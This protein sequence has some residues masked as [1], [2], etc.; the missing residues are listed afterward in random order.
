MEIFCFPRFKERKLEYKFETR[1][2]TYFPASSRVRGNLNLRNLKKKGS[3]SSFD[4]EKRTVRQS[5]DHQSVWN[6]VLSRL[7]ACARLALDNYR[8][9]IKIFVERA[10]VSCKWALAWM[11]EAAA[12]AFARET[13]GQSVPARSSC[14]RAHAWR[15]TF[16]SWN[17]RTRAN[18]R[19]GTGENTSLSLSLRP[20]RAKCNGQGRLLAKIVRVRC[21]FLLP[22]LSEERI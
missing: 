6:R 15:A 3:W 4:I 7:D 16:A 11:A 20:W 10:C 21:I 1:R 5:R 22:W 12:G 18:A 8:V 17:V 14:A 9:P 2:E 13:R 19:I